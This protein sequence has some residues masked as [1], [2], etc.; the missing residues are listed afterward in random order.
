M[1]ST[2]PGPSRNIPT[3]ESVPNYVAFASTVIE[4]PPPYVVKPMAPSFAMSYI[5]VTCTSNTTTAPDT[6]EGG[7][8]FPVDQ[9]SL[10]LQD[11]DETLLPPSYPEL[12]PLEP[13]RAILK[14]Q[15]G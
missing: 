8:A 9:K 11:S 12:Q 6:M 13:R 2:H 7:W 3:P 1:C 14:I 10:A 5:C 4:M 15:I